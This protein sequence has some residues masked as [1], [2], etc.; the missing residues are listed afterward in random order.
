MTEL[1]LTDCINRICP[2]SGN[3]VAPDSLT[4]YKG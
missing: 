3:P 4:R 2:W 1:K